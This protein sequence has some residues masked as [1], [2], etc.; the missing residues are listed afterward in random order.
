MVTPSR[1]VLITIFFD[2][3]MQ[4]TLLKTIV[5]SIAGQSAAS[6]VDLLYEKK[7]VNEFLIAKKLKLTINQTRNILYRLA[8]EGLVSFVRKKDTKKGG[9]YTYFWTL[10]SGKSLLKF[11]DNLIK[12]ITNLQQQAQIRKSTSFFLCKNCE[13]EFN[14]ES[15]LTHDYTCPECGSVLEAKDTA[16]E[17]AQ[18]EKEIAKLQAVLSKVNE[19]VELLNVK[20]TKARERRIKTEERKKAQERAAHKIALARAKRKLEKPAKKKTVK[21]KNKTSRTSSKKKR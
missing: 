10:S 15:A 11:H 14:E 16:E 21:A 13:L 2:I 12:T 18:I 1:K 17:V 20:E 7:N 3:W 8:D 4:I 5:A 6:A 9:W 19:E